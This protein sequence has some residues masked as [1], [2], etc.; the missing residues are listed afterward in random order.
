MAESAQKIL[1]Q[2]Y[3]REIRQR[4]G[5]GLRRSYDTT[6]REPLPS[7]WLQLIDDLEAR[8]GSPATTSSGVLERLWHRLR[9]G[10]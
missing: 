10:E 4:L 8:R 5:D 9:L 2:A 1:A 7:D 3:E 6:V